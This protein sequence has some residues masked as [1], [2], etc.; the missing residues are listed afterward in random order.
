[1]KRLF[2]LVSV[3][4]IISLLGAATVFA[5]GGG[6]GGKGSKGTNAA[7]C[8]GKQEKVHPFAEGIAESYGASTDAVMAYYCDG[9]SFGEIMLALQTQRLNGSDA[10]GLLANVR[11]GQGW[12]QMWTEMGLLGKPE[13]GESPPGF[14]KRPAFAGPP[15]GRGPDGEQGPDGEK[16]PNGNGGEGGDEGED[17]D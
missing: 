13:D 1:M 4:L 9:S 10:G 11:N 12:G 8:S 2:S 5:Q 7:Y 14:L 17:A 3:V 15:E 16:G 6:E